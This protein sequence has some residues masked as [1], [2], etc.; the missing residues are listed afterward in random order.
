MIKLVHDNLLCV[1]S[2]EDAEVLQENPIKLED[3]ATLSNVT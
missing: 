2:R 1:R 3:Y